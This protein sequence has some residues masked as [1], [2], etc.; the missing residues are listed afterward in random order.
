MGGATHA[1]RG[2]RGLT[3]ALAGLLALSGSSLAL[4]STASARAAE[5]TAHSS[6]TLTVQVTGLP[7]HAHGN[8]KLVG[9]GKKSHKITATTKLTGVA[10]ATYTVT[11][12]SVAAGTK[13]YHPTVQLC[14][15]SGH[16]STPSHGRIT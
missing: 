12:Q 9:P 5:A 6:A 15:S 14:G 13:T 3:A 7:K 8:V 4:L 1:R 2:T 11:A 16:C 10:P